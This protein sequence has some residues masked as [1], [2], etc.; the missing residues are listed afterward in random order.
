MRDGRLVLPKTDDKEKAQGPALISA[1]KLCELAH[2]LAFTARLAK[3][4]LD[5]STGL[6][7]PCAAARRPPP[8]PPPTAA[9]RA[10]RRSPCP[11]PG[12]VRRPGRWLRSSRP[13][14][15]PTV[16]SGLCRPGF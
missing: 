3:T 8:P 1:R 16:L 13:A 14:D 12:A 7:D 15:S 4:R 10:R 2:D 9:N 11:T 6:V 5:P